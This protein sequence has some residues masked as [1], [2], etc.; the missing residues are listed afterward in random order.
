MVRATFRIRV[1]ARAL[2]PSRS[3]AISISCR[4]SS[5]IGQ[6]VAD[7]AVGQAGVEQGF[8]AGEALFLDLARPFDPGL[9][10]GRRLARFPCRQ[11]AVAD[12]GDLDMDVDP[13]EERSGDPPLVLADLLGRAA[14]GAAPVAEV[15]A[16][17]GIHRRDEH[18]PGGIGGRQARSG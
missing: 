2:S 15:A 3:T 7:L 18:E 12:R 10:R 13:V 5:S 1:W 4:E 11:I 8:V 14:A 9:D 17:A 6:T 16:G